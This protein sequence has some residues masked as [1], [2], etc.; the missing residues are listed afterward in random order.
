M[1]HLV[2]TDSELEIL[3]LLWE[4]GECSVRFINEELNKKRD[5]GYTTTLKIMQIMNDKNLV[6]RNTEN[7]IH[8]YKA[9]LKEK[10]TKD[11][12]MNNFI[13]NTFNGSAKDL[14]MAALGSYKSS[15][16]ELDEIKKLISDIENKK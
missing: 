3:H 1:S 13:T 4:H 7:K 12:L 5:V 6:D 16:K 14:V 8:L 10:K 2:P 15:E 11:H 9:K